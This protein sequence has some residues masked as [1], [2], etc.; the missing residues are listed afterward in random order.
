M[1]TLIPALRALTL[2]TALCAGALA[3]D[4]G[5]YQSTVENQSGPPMLGIEMSPVPTTVQERD[6]LTP[7]QGVYVQNT[8]N[9]TAASSMGIQPGDVVMSV[10]GT[11]IGSMSDLRNEVGLNAVGEPVEVTVSRN[12]QQMTM[13]APLQEW[14]KEIPRE[15]IDPESEKRFRQWQQDRMAQQRRQLDDAQKKL[16]A[17][18]KNFRQLPDAAALGRALELQNRLGAQPWELSWALDH[19][20][21]DAPVAV[22]ATEPA[23]QPEAA[24]AAWRFSWSNRHADIGATP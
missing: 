15:R 10:N 18:D 3:A 17:A 2:G 1:A 9:N 5:D 8:F 13:G 22:A 21:H 24:D 7:N 23:A 4:G 19:R 20:D 12:G 14:P 11:P 6:G 16:A